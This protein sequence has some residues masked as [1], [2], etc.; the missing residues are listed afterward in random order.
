MGGHLYSRLYNT[1]PDK[2][3]RAM[4]ILEPSHNDTSDARR[5]FA[6]KKNHA[7]PELD[8]GNQT[9]ATFNNALPMMP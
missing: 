9:P 7:E 1:L 2:Y 8:L 6:K 4:S 5:G 3:G